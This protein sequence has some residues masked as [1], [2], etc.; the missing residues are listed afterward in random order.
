MCVC[1][2]I[3][4]I[5]IIII[6]TCVYILY[7]Y[8]CT[9]YYIHIYMCKFIIYTCMYIYMCVY[10]YVY[11]LYIWKHYTLIKCS[12]IKEKN[13][14]ES[15]RKWASLGRGVGCWMGK[16]TVGDML[17]VY[18]IHMELL[19]KTNHI[20]YLLEIGPNIREGL[21]SQQDG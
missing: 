15:R 18:N 7:T 6:Y 19:N 10:L 2:Y 4:Y 11:M 14:H 3:L 9:T 20:W 16:R 17:R 1:T 8:I 21:P 12:G 5:Y 13:R